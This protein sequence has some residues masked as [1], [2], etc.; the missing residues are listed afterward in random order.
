M[1]PSGSLFGASENLLGG[2][3]FGNL[4][5]WRESGVNRL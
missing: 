3:L 5:A 2:E 1:E 4:K